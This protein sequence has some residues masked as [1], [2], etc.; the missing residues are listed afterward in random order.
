MRNS[1]SRLEAFGIDDLALLVAHNGN[2]KTEQ[3]RR[4]EEEA[5][6]EEA[7]KIAQDAADVTHRIDLV[8]ALDTHIDLIAANV[9]TASGDEKKALE[10][11]IAD[12]KK[13]R[14]DAY[15]A[16]QKDRLDAAQAEI[17]A[18]GA[19]IK[20]AQGAEL[21]ALTAHQALMIAEYGLLAGAINTELDKIDS[22]KLID[23]V[24]NIR[25]GVS[26]IAGSSGSTTTRDSGGTQTSN[27]TV[28][29]DGS[30]TY[31]ESFS[32]D[33]GGPAA[34][35]SQS[36]FTD[37][38]GNVFYDEALNNPASDEAQ[39]AYDET[40]GAAHGA[41]VLPR[42][43][44]TRVNVGEAGRAEAIVPLPDLAALAGNLMAGIGGGRGVGGGMADGSGGSGREVVLALDGE[45]L[46]SVFLDQ[47][48]ILQSENRL[49]VDLV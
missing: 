29:P 26:S 36:L 45:R 11:Q 37:S 6:T 31:S 34:S 14:D 3:E 41:I 38:A 19:K 24:A 32:G 35:S 21:A 47:F 17:D 18:V 12:L 23:I 13:Q 33:E 27:V 4:I 39:Q 40:Q 7:A 44:G 43:G 28:N 42:T 5:K 1:L 49:L 2:L 9:L 20:G 16:S 48:N 10:T 30:I 8:S 15:T 22:P 46:G 25:G